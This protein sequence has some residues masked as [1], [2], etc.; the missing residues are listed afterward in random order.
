MF[1]ATFPMRT[2]RARRC[3]PPLLAARRSSACPVQDSLSSRHS[4]IESSDVTGPVLVHV[5]RLAG[6][7]GAIASLARQAVRLQ[8]QTM[9]P[10][11]T[12]GDLP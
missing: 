9:S 3:D 6:K 1:A 7:E 10:T 5:G 11:T 12:Q 8:T 2:P 4:G